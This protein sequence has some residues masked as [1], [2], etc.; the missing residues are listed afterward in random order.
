MSSIHPDQ[1]L[2][3]ADQNL[4]ALFALFTACCVAASHITQTS[5]K[6]SVVICL[7]TLVYLFYEYAYHQT[8]ERYTARDQRIFF[9]L[10]I[11]SGTAIR[12]LVSVKGYGN[13]DS[14]S[15]EQVGQILAR[16]ENV[17]NHTTRYNTSPLWFW[18]L[19]GLNKV[20]LIGNVIPY[21]SWVRI[22]LS[23]VDLAT[24]ILIWKS[25]R[26]LGVPKAVALSFFY[27]N[28]V[29]ILL[30]SYHAQFENIAI[31][32]LL[33]GVYLYSRPSP[34]AKWRQAL[35][36]SFVTLGLIAKHNICYEVP[37]VLRFVFGKLRNWAILFI[38]SCLVFFASFWPYWHESGQAI[39]K[40][41]LLYGS[42][43]M[44]YGISTLVQAAWL[45]YI[46][47]FALLGYAFIQRSQ[48][49]V[50]RCLQGTLF[51]LTFTPGF[52]HQ[53]LVLPVA[54]G[55]LRP[56]KLFFVF[57]IVTSLA[58]MGSDR[59]IYIK[60][61]SWVPLNAVWICVLV[62]FVSVHAQASETSGS[63]GRVVHEGEKESRT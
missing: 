62:W 40:N 59:N 2:T 6:A 15:W 36:W 20:A 31:F 25:A 1:S 50:T 48:D 55:A 33:T 37:I 5:Y 26:C 35:M 27:L 22:F 44:S 10:V 23:G 61:L 54:L 17:Y 39:V 11:L 42:Y 57:T 34:S 47:L 51:F 8:W 21:R 9:W 43:P 14:V 12:V 19:S 13:Y 24:A 63:L 41:V 56:S 58:I 16:G 29:S 4:G 7:L 28:P 46:F 18:I 3:R 53:Y 30:S 32:F 52:G 60:A 45:K 49:L 38:L